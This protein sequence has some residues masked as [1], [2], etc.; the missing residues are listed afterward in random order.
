MLLLFV[1]PFFFVVLLL[2][3]SDWTGTRVAIEGI[4]VVPAKVEARVFARGSGHAWHVPTG[5]TSARGSVG[6]QHF[7]RGG[8]GKARGVH[9]RG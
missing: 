2:R 8:E 3:S 5:E 7:V 6:I 4:Q 1:H 9:R